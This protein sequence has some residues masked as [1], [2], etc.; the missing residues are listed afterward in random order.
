MWNKAY[1]LSLN[2]LKKSPIMIVLSWIVIIIATA[3]IIMLYNVMESPDPYHD[4]LLI[5]IVTALPLFFRRKV[6]R[7]NSGGKMRNSEMIILYN[8]L[9]IPKKVIAKQQIFIYIV[10]CIPAYIGMMIILYTLDKVVNQLSIGQFLLFVVVMLSISFF[11]GLTT[12]LGDFGS[13]YHN[14]IFWIIVSAIVFIVVFFGVILGMFSRF[15]YGNGLLLRGIELMIAHPYIALFISLFIAF[16][17]IGL[18]PKMAE[19]KLRKLDF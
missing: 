7:P 19:R 6:F 3:M 1:E 2:E 10:Y 9:P 16:I 13:K 8:G 14:N 5:I 12:L 18:F 15:S 4:I 11:F 17:S